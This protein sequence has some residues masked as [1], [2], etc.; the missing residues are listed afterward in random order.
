MSYKLDDESSKKSG[1]LTA[2]VPQVFVS[3]VSPEKRL[4]ANHKEEHD[5]IKGMKGKNQPPEWSDYKSMP[6]SQCI[7]N[8]TL[9]VANIISLG[10]NRGRLNQTRNRTISGAGMDEGNPSTVSPEKR[11]CANHK[12]TEDLENA[13]AMDTH[14]SKRSRLHRISPSYS[15]FDHEVCD[16]LIDGCK[17]TPEASLHNEMAPNEVTPPYALRVIAI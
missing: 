10:S 1:S 14:M 2:V 13:P 11:L 7:I 8:E 17:S 6:F 3:T 15:L 4:C 9:R 12:V 5:N 16:E